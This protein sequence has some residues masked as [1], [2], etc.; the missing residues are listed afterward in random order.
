ME[1]VSF[2]SNNHQPKFDLN[3]MYGSAMRILN[4][5]KIYL[6]NITIYGCLSD[7]STTGIIIT[8]DFYY[9][10]LNKPYVMQNTEFLIIF[11]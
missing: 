7:Y 4:T 6:L 10:D 11:I 5:A 9:S 2:I 3:S 8:H 1:V